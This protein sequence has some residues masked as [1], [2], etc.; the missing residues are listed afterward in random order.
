MSWNSVRFDWNR[1]RAFLVTAEEGSYSAA[2]RALGLTQPTVGRQV[3]ALEEELGVVLFERVGNSLELTDSGQELLEHARTMGEAATSLSLTAAG[4]SSEVD[5]LV[6]ITASQLISA[7][8]LPDVVG[9]LRAAHPGIT[10]HLVASNTLHDLRRREADLAIR[11]AAP[12]HADLIARRLPDAAARMYATPDYLASI[13]DPD[14]P[15]ALAERASIFGFDDVERMISGLNH[16]GLP[17]TGANFPVVTEDHLVQWSMAR[18]S[19]GIA[20]VM[21]QVGDADPDMVR[22]LPDAVPAIPIPMWLLCHRE[23]RTSRRLRIVFDAIAEALS[24]GA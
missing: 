18:R 9:N 24:A 4:Q 12:A 22:V 3:Q 5:G 8:L 14:T 19:L 2:A 23:V 13:G 10:L 6:R 17:L 1:T 7:Y 16:L 11:N 15:D 20:L 21:E